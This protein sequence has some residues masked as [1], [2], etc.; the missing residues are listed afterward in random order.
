MHNTDTEGYTIPLELWI[1]IPVKEGTPPPVGRCVPLPPTE[2]DK[3]HPIETGRG[4]NGLYKE[5]ESG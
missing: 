5:G 3:K 2:T 4:G 1:P